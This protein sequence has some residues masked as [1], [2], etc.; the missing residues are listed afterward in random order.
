MKMIFSRLTGLALVVAATVVGPSV[1][2]AQNPP[3]GSIFDL[4]TAHPA[5]LTTYTQFTTSFVAD[6]TGT[7]YVSFAFREAPAYF[8][9]DDASVV[10]NGTSTNLLADPGFE[11]A[12]FGQNCNHNNSLGCP[13]GWSAWIQPVDTSAI[14]Q[15]ATTSSPYGCNVGANSGTTFWC[16]GSVQGYDGIYQGIS[17]TL[18]QTYNIS[19]WLEDDSESG[20]TN[21]TVDMLVYAGDSIPVGTVSIGGVP[22]PLTFGLTGFG[23]AALGFLRLRR[24]A[25]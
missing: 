10:L 16:D 4:A 17:T 22:E 21:P 8:A 3:A 6:I 12:A 25:A 19:F 24:R 7:E 11:S 20:I 5:A 14:G 15:I 13:S 9:F 2:Q 1:A 18:G 23:L